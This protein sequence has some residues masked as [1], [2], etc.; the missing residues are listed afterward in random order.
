MDEISGAGNANDNND[1]SNNLQE[2]EAE[3]I[4]SGKKQLKL[5][6]SL[7]S[8]N[9]S[10]QPSKQISELASKVISE[11]RRSFETKYGSKKHRDQLNERKY[12]RF[13]EM[14]QKFN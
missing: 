5:D 12:D 13:D 8:P 6:H 14:L 7:K 3:N 11:S 1:G 4:V 9:T 10:L 2:L